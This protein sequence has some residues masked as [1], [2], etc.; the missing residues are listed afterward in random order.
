MMF[1]GKSR[2]IDVV[3]QDFLVMMKKHHESDLLCFVRNDPKYFN[4]Q[5]DRIMLSFI[6]IGYVLMFQQYSRASEH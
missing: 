2:K 1:F 5:M 6:F 3:T 4:T